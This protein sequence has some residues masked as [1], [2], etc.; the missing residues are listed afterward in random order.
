MDAGVK[1]IRISLTRK[2]TRVIFANKLKKMHNKTEH[3]VRNYLKGA[4]TNGNRRVVFG[5]AKIISL[6]ILIL[7]VTNIIISVLGLIIIIR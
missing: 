3:I 4:A 1:K 6:D 7:G 5:T 2:K